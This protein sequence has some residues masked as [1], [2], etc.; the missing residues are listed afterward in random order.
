MTL[1]F[2]GE[3]SGD[4]YFDIVPRAVV[5]I[6]NVPTI[7][8]S[9]DLTTN[10]YLETDN[11]TISIPMELIDIK[12]IMKTTRSNSDIVTIELWSGFLNSQS[13]QHLFTQS[14][15]NMKSNDRLKKDF[16]ND[17]IYKK[18]LP[19][20]W[21]GC[22]DKISLF[23]GEKEQADMITIH[24]V[25]LFTKLQDYMYEKEYKEDEGTV[26][27]VIDDL[28][29]Y[30]KKF[31]IEIDK[32]VTQ[33]QLNLLLGSKVKYK[34]DNEDGSEG[35]EEKEDKKYST[36]GK[37]VFE[38]I[39]DIC[40][41]AKLEFVQSDDNPFTYIFTPLYTPSKQWNLDRALH[42]TSCK[43][44]QG[45]GSSSNKGKCTFVLKSIQNKD[46]SVVEYTY[47]EELQNDSAETMLK[48]VINVENNLTKDQLKSR[49][50]DYFLNYSKGSMSG[51]INIP[52]A[53]TMLKPY[54]QI[55]LK[56][57]SNVHPLRKINL[58]DDKG[59]L[60]KFKITSIQEKFNKEDGLTQDSVEFQLSDYLYTIDIKSGAIMYD[61]TLVSKPS[62]SGETNL[63]DSPP[64][65][66]NM[67]SSAVQLPKE[68]NISQ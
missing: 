28:K 44:D 49:A 63:A 52:N 56:D 8:L 2:K 34:K 64:K 61:K 36:F 27:R 9:Y 17:K 21:F 7:P 6:N 1:D 14:M 20:R 13:P 19:L 53:I 12:E 3:Y 33:Q 51:S 22:V 50:L 10:A 57:T 55:T 30:L 4:S 42:F 48:R 54:H 58:V 41:K 66:A 35:T 24:A 62:N 38:V 65:L 25:E 26:K 32:N 11:L 59:N 23:Y 46:A 15:T 5:V 37:T 43:I 47:P 67:R 39:K 18:T 60:L 68:P 29:K 45:D 40:A 16:I 31:K